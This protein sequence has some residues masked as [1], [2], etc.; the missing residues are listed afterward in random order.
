MQLKL[1]SRKPQ[2]MVTT[3]HTTYETLEILA[4]ANPGMTISALAKICLE[5]GLPAVAEAYAPSKAKD[6]LRHAP[7]FHPEFKKVAKA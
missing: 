1:T 5:A 6:R 7:D 3:E 2:V 4:Q